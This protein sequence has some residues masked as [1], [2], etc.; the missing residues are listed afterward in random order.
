MT[1]K[2]NQKSGV[3]FWMFK[4]PVAL[5]QVLDNVRRERIKRGK[6]LEM[7]S[8]RRLGLAIARHNNL[9]RDLMNADMKEEMKNEQ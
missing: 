1:S 4:A 3:S 9:I 8:Y 2:S 5:K 6:D 7:K